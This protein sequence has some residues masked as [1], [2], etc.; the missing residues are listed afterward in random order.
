MSIQAV[1]FDMGGTIETMAVSRELRLQATAGLQELLHTAGI[2]LALTDEQLYEV[3]VQGW[4]RYHTQ[5]I[6]TEEEL[7]PAQ[8]WKEYIL[9]EYPATHAALDVLAEELMVFLEMHY[10]QRQMRPEMPQ[11]LAA[12]Q[13]MGLKIGLISNVCSHSQVEDTLQ[14]YGIRHY[15]D[16]IILSSKYGRRKPDPAIFHHA[17]RLIN[18]PTSQCVYIGDRIAR[19]I[20]GARRAGFRLAVQ[21][22]HHY[23]HGETDHGAQPDAV[24]SQMTEL[25][26]LLQTELDRSPTAEKKN[27]GVRAIFFDAGDIL[28][29][30][31]NR[32]MYFKAFLTE[33][34][35]A[36]REIAE[37]K[38]K[39]LRLQAFCGDI[40]PHQLR[41]SI[42]EL[43]GITAPNL[44]ERG[45]CALTN[46]ENN[47]QF[48][49]GVAE[50]LKALKAQGFLLGIITDTA[51]PV[52]VKL[53]WFENGGFGHVWDAIIS[54]QEVGVE[55]P[56]PLI[57]QAALRQFGLT[58]KEAVFVGHSPEELDGAR[59]LGIYTI[60]FNYPPNAQADLYIDHFSDLLHS[61]SLTQDRLL[62]T[63]QVV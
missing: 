45:E 44:L 34:G 35:M 60:A 61:I 38:R 20:L 46:D 28:Y 58:A 10:Y 2:H 13:K 36:D 39:A 49:D 23:K 40:T 3:V 51:N 53:R 17:A 52:S 56:D 19:D 27:A 63:S 4:E 59:A 33:L 47:V 32:G 54:S 29:H 18:A 1:L 16:P 31:P 12:I 37:E 50:T 55:K 30:R 15:F 11:V 5:V 9:A 43:Y 26:P 22:H 57:Y 62:Q 24:I 42:L 21:I 7:S 14:K 25:L 48:F 6:A 41:Q 8:V